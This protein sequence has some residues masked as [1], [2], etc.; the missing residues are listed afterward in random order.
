VIHIELTE[1]EANAIV[2]MAFGV[3]CDIEAAKAA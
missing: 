1:A 2:E 3:D